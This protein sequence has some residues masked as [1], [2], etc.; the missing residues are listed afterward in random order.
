VDVAGTLPK[1]S[2]EWPGKHRSLSALTLANKNVDSMYALEGTVAVPNWAVKSEAKVEAARD[3]DLLTSWSCEATAPVAEGGA[4]AEGNADAAGTPESDATARCALGVAFPELAKVQALRLHGSTGATWTQYKAQPRLKL[5]RIHTDRGWIDVKLPDVTTPRYIHFSEPIETKS[6]VIEVLETYSG[7]KGKAAHVSELEVYGTAG[8]ARAPLEF[9]VERARFSFTSS[10]WKAS[11]KKFAAMPNYLEEIRPDESIRRIAPGTA[12]YGKKGDRM[13]LVERWSQSDCTNPEGTFTLVDRERRMFI[14][15]GEMGDLMARVQ[16]HRDGLGFA[17]G[18]PKKVP[19]GVNA[20]GLDE[21]SGTIKRL[22]PPKDVEAE[23]EE[24]LV[25]QWGF[26]LEPMTREMA[27]EAGSTAR[28]PSDCRIATADDVAAADPKL[29]KL[30]GEAAW[31]SCNG[32]HDTDVL[33]RAPLTD[34][35]GKKHVQVSKNA[36]SRS[37]RVK[38]LGDHL[39]FE[40]DRAKGDKADLW[41][42]GDDGKPERMRSGAGF[43]LRA[44]AGCAC[45]PPPSDGSVPAGADTKPNDALADDEED[46]EGEPVELPNVDA[47]ATA[48]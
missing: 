35:S 17:V 47:E 32:Q 3:D 9:D 31:I 19:F 30:E 20:I 37:P 42:I 36:D 2:A 4:A 25:R 38:R 34:T 6:V 29:A 46:G 45:V 5:V 12:V 48:G 13:L 1:A 11:G 10:R 14:D 7:K 44:P 15:I 39:Y 41:T 43:S 21:A 16:R 27:W 26:E 28:P 40:L 33:V 8:K 24:E 23:T 22:R 18:D